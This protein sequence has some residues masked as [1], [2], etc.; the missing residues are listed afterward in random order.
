[1]RILEKSA[2]RALRVL[3]AGAMV[4]ISPVVALA[5]NS[6]IHAS[7][8]GIYVT[9]A[10]KTAPTMSVSLGADGSATVTQDPGQGSSTFFGHWEDDGRQV[11]VTFNATAGEQPPAPMVFEPTHDKLKA[12][13]WDHQTWGT[14]Q[15]PTMAK[16]YKVKYLFWTT[17]MR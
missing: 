12:I 5:A 10:P 2:T 1:M 4:S 3:L 6:H 14:T 11:K 15:P 13:S 7:F 9:R 8:A 17:T 16:G